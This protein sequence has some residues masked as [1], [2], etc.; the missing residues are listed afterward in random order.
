M[1]VNISKFLNNSL[2]MVK[3]FNK[4]TKNNIKNK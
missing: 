3:Y 2:F 1:K 4:F